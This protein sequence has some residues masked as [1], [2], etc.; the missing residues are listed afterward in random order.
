M[1]LCYETMYKKGCKFLLL[2]IQIKILWKKKIILHLKS[3][4]ATYKFSKG[5]TVTHAKPHLNTTASIMFE[6]VV[7]CT[8]PSIQNTRNMPTKKMCN[9]FLHSFF[10]LFICDRS[11]SAS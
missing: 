11:K 8:Y 4:Y 7:I 1:N 10:A 9:L 6:P 5:K 2:K 3:H